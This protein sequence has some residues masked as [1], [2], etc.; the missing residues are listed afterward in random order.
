MFQGAQWKGFGCRREEAGKRRKKGCESVP[1]QEEINL[2][3]WV[4]TRKEG[5]EACVGS[6]S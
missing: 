5:R 6:E 2:L 3:L 1:V 4:V